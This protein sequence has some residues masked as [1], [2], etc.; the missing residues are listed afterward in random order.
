MERLFVNVTVDNLAPC[1]KLVRVEVEAEK[2]NETFDSVV[3]EFRREARLPGFRPGKAPVEMVLR[4]FGKEIED[5]TKRKLINESYKQAIEEQKLDVVGQP[6]VE[7]IEFSRGQPLKFVATVETAPE[8][9]LPEYKGIPV[10]RVALT[11]T[12][13]D[14]DRA[15]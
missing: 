10:K 13:E 8:F 9:E 1:K 15:I 4:Q 14:V 7:E 12:E 3:R 11:V 6:D 5:E 2:V